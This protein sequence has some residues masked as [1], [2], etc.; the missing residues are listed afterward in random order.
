MRRLFRHVVHFNQERLDKWVSDRAREVPSG[1]RVLDVGAGGG[2]YRAL[3][4]HCEY[5]THDF[6]QLKS[7]Q[8]IQ[9]KYAAIDYVSDI[10][11]IPVGDGSFDV[12]LSTEVLEHVPR[13]ID[14][15]KEMARILSTGG[16]LLLTVPL[17]SGI[18]QEPYHFY[19]GYT[20]YFFE[21]FLNACGFTEIEVTPK[22]G[23]FSHF[24]QWLVWFFKRS[25]PF[26]LRLGLPSQVLLFPIYLLQLPSVVWLFFY[27]RLVDSAEDRFQFTGGYYVRATRGSRAG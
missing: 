1:A 5:K 26:S 15:L 6:G 11:N 14:A 21:F 19:G 22:G 10:T 24:A 25:N 13:P 20:P 27:C 17:G 4:A 23:S 7:E 18:H 16:Q 3:F 12:I 9:G 8:I 2:P